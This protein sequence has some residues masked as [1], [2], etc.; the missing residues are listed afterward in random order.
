LLSR[1][2]SPARGRDTYLDVVVVNRE[3]L[4]QQALASLRRLNGSQLARVVEAV[5][6]VRLVPL[7][8]RDMFLLRRG[9]AADRSERR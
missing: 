4:I 6:A 5:C 9:G 2:S 3:F 8:A 1:Q 7:S